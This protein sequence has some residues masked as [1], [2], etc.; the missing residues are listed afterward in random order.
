[1]IC[2]HHNDLDGK[3]AAAIVKRAYDFGHFLVDNNQE[4][5]FREIDYKDN[6]DFTKEFKFGEIVV[7]VDFSFKPEKMK[8]L[9]HG[10]DK[11]RV[12]W[13]D[14]HETAKEYDYGVDLPGLRDFS[15]EC[16]KA[17]CELAWEHFFPAA[18]MP[19]AVQLLGD[20][21]TWTFKYKEKTELFQ[22]GMKMFDSDPN[23]GE[24]ALLFCG[25]SGSGRLI[26]EAVLQGTLILRYRDRFC[27]NYRK[28]CA[29]E[30][31]F[32][33]YNCIAMNLHQLGSQAFGDEVDKYDIAIAFVWDGEQWTVS[34]Y[35]S[36][37]H[38]GEIA[39]KHG[40]GGHKGAAGFV[41]KELPF[42]RK[43]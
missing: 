24:W 9:L 1:M 6:P 19:E 4:L 10:T 20:Y 27:L 28:H 41:C 12:I 14:H 16:K 8:E 37:I 2:Y 17:G 40:G 39:K 32:E 36:G 30:T 25:P 23:N 43:K 3:C 29:F 33:G 38:V 34:M 15:P 7:I 18:D 26:K 5:R 35:S 13:I 11:E 22:Q 42:S 31:N 21:D